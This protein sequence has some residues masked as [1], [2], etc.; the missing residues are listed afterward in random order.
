LY[1]RKF[2][3]VIITALM[4]C[5]GFS[6]V[7]TD[8]AEG[9]LFI[10]SIQTPIPD[11]TFVPN[12]VAWTPDGHVALVVG[13]G[14]GGS[15]WAYD[16]YQDM[17][18][19]LIGYDS[20]QTFQGVSYDQFSNL[21]W[22]CGNYGSTGPSTVY[23]W[24]PPSG[25]T[26]GFL[27]GTGGGPLTVPVMD[28]AA[29]IT[30]SPLAVGL[31]GSVYYYGTDWFLLDGILS[32]DF[33]AVD[34][35]THDDRF[36]FGGMYQP[37]RGASGQGQ[38]FYSDICPLTPGSP[39][40]ED[41]GYHGTEW[42]TIYDIAWNQVYNY[43]L[44][45]GETVNTVTGALFWNEIKGLELLGTQTI[46]TSASWDSD[47]WKEAAIVGEQYQDD[48]YFA[49]R[50]AYWRYYDGGT[51]IILGHVDSTELVYNCVA[52][53]P[54]ASPKW[55]IIP[56]AGGGGVKINVFMLDQST[57]VR[58]NSAFPHIFSIDMWDQASALGTLNGPSLL[59]AE[60]DVGNVYTFELEANY[61]IATANHW[62]D[63]EIELTAW[64]DE[65]I[66]GTNS[67]PEGSFATVDNRT[68]QFRMYYN[69]LN[70]TAWMTYPVAPELEF[71]IAPLDWYCYPTPATVDHYSVY[72]NVSF[73]LQ[74]RAAD[75]SLWGVGPAGDIF[76]PNLAFNDLF[77]WDFNYTVYDVNFTSAL[78]SAYDEFGVKEAVAISAIGNPTGN[79]P[80]GS[81]DVPLGPQSIITYSA[82][83]PYWVN[84]SI[85]NLLLGGVGPQN[86]P[87]ADIAIRNDHIN[88][89]YSNSDIGQTPLAG[90]HFTGPGAEW[91]VWGNRSLPT[92]YMSAPLNGTIAGG[93]W[94]SDYSA[95]TVPGVQVTLISW[96]ASVGLV[97]E[98]VYWATITFSIYDT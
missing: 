93:E 68:R 12:D 84:V 60:V 18:F 61:S 86:I 79:A 77:S 33:Y 58:V 37:G 9:M 35:N 73:G 15:A 52:M 74:T 71:S 56:L 72:L 3:V 13:S 24:D 70:D 92:T 55:A 25:L 54:P 89:S 22:F 76:Q 51:E 17:W 39:A 83:T 44:V 98:G 4:L 45:V 90:R 14:S 23:F 95:L 48:P 36:Y 59:N 34:Y 20:T 26:V 94:G 69:P 47:G 65:G 29:D 27:P 97:P 8:D 40:N 38:F 64:Y 30:G 96:W 42:G 19:A 1:M 66:L 2:T 87:A 50:G 82:N 31:G 11:G 67:G 78:E 43:G 85:P 41:T 75:G 16:T 21:F 6:I 81:S 49:P 32:T 53:K 80:P 7:S 88:A 62:Y 46:Y 91:S 5:V 63:T 57:I 28:V 10:E